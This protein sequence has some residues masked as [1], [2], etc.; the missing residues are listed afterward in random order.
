MRISPKEFLKAKRPERFSDSIVISESPMA[1]PFL[2]E[3]LKTLANRNQEMM[4]ERFGT[5]LCR[6]AIA[7]NLV[8]NTGPTGGGDGKVDSE[9]YPVSDATALT[10]H[11]CVDPRAANER[12]G[13][14]FSVKKKW[15]DKLK[16]DVRKLRESG[17]GYTRAYFVSSQYIRAKERQQAQDELRAKYG[18]DVRILDM[19]WILDQVYENRR[20]DIVRE[21]LDAQLN[22]EPVGKTGPLDL[23]R[24]RELDALEKRIETST[25]EGKTDN[26]VVGD[27]IESA[28]LSRE[29]EKPPTEID[30]RFVRAKRLAERYGSQYQQF[31][32][33]YQWA[34]TAF[35]Y[36]E[37]QPMFVDMYSSAQDA[38]VSADNVYNLERLVTLWLNLAT[39]HFLSQ[40]ILSDDDYEARTKALRAKLDRIAEDKE[41]KPSASLYA[42]TLL[43]QMELIDK[44]HREVGVDSTLKG[45]N[46]IVCESRGLIGFPLERLVDCL[47][48]IGERL[49]S[50]PECG[51]LFD[52]I[53]QVTGEREGELAEANLFL[54]RGEKLVQLGRHYQGIQVLGNSLTK[55]YK[56]KSKDDL[57]R[58]LHLI[59]I[60]YEEVGLIWAARGALLAAASLATS[61]IWNYGDIN[62]MQALCCKRLK[63]LELRLGRIPQALDWHSA[64]SGIRNILLGQGYNGPPLF[65]DVDRFDLYIGVLF[66]RSDLQTLKTLESLPD[67][68]SELGLYMSPIALMYA[69]VYRSVNNIA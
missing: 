18:I 15:H 12:W 60:A 48:E 40:G 33:A 56:H 8:S 35:W 4:F 52:S 13:F 5:R 6:L 23:R 61:D 2:E 28:I 42:R 3:Y 57:V 9:T 62:A 34:W 24:Q 22:T 37:D 51:I 53:A 10:W 30:G 65:E 38:V 7:P 46:D 41:G 67:T 27:A 20:H 63:F 25:A 49:E 39:I 31:E 11:T 26:S 32:V 47:T 68:L 50:S 44:I 58:A 19:T 17:R 14:A 64:D 59:G 21:E 54:R 16:D 1:R 45:L 29:L 69:L 43:L 55:L 36:S 66:L